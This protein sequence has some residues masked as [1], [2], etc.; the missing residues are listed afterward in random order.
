MSQRY[1]PR[2]FGDYQFPSTDSAQLSRGRIVEERRLEN[3]GRITVT[4]LEGTRRRKWEVRA[5][6]TVHPDGQPPRTIVE[7]AHADDELDVRMTMRRLE[8]RAHR[9]P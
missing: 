8:A 2:W 1:G 6:W 9:E 4:P 5:E 7:T 3:G